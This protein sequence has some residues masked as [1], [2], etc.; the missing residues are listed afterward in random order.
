MTL[1]FKYQLSNGIKGKQV[2][3]GFQIFSILISS[4]WR[5]KQG[6]EDFNIRQCVK[7]KN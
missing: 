7:Q 1:L 5:Q 2:K 6:R 4:S 3:T